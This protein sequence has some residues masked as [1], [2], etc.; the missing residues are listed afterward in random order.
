[1]VGGVWV[2]WVVVSKREKMK[3]KG[4]VLWPGRGG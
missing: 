3:V 1:M 2:W 4:G